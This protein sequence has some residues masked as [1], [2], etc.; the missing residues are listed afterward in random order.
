M[1]ST[2]LVFY[3]EGRRIEPKQTRVLALH[4]V[5]G[6]IEG[7]FE[8]E[9]KGSAFIRIS[10]HLKDQQEY[11]G[12]GLRMKYNLDPFAPYLLCSTNHVIFLS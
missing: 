9:G 8:G 6:F 11:L 3:I 1:N 7:M 2:S 5:Y 10:D 12:L 4:P